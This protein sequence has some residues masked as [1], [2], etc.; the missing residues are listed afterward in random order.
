MNLFKEGMLFWKQDHILHQG[1][2]TNNQ[3]KYV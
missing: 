1:Q 3:E 2:Y